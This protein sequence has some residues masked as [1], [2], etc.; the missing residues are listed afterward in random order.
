MRGVQGGVACGGGAGGC[1]VGWR[2][3]VEGGGALGDMPFA[4]H[5]PPPRISILGSAHST[6]ARDHARAGGAGVAGVARGQQQADE[7]GRRRAEA[8]IKE[9]WM[10]LAGGEEE[11]EE[12]ELLAA[13]RLIDGAIH[14]WAS[15][16]KPAGREQ[17]YVCVCTYIY[18]EF[19]CMCMYVCMYVC[20]YVYIYIYSVCVCVY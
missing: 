11:E 4:G 15:L 1:G 2:V 6:L 20:I 19:V 8:L 3:G 5:A 9:A 17:V 18:I 7:P 12:E 14:E 10:A 13:Q 16:G